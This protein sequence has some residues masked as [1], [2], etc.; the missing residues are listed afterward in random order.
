MYAAYVTAPA[1][2]S[3]WKLPSNVP[4]FVMKTGTVVA[5]DN[6]AY[7]KGRITYTLAG[8]ENGAIRSDEIDWA[9]TARVNVGRGFRMT[10]RANHSG[11]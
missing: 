6:Y 3:A 5:V 7:Q 4:C 2:A 9:T 10:L 11:S 8:G 1:E